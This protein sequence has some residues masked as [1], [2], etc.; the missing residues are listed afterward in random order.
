MYVTKLSS[1]SFPTVFLIKKN[2]N[3]NNGNTF[4]LNHKYV[5]AMQTDHA[6]RSTNKQH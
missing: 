3:D 5:L 2:N 6:T 4:W 1:F